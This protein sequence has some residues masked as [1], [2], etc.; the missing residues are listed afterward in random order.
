MKCPSCEVS[1]GYG[2]VD[3]RVSKIEFDGNLPHAEVYVELTCEMCG[4]PLLEAVAFVETKI[5]HKCKAKPRN[6]KQ[7]KVPEYREGDPQYKVESDGEA[8][9]SEYWG[10]VKDELG[11][12]LI[13]RRRGLSSHRHLGHNKGRG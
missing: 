11:K 5:E 8:Q 9:G 4:D 2:G 6:K 12:P 7:K 1:V 13:P 3:C 10:P